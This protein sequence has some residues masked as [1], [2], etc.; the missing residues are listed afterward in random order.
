MR[1]R[2]IGSAVEA[3]V[4]AMIAGSAAFGQL[5]ISPT[6]VELTGY[7]GGLETFVLGLSNSG[8]T[9][10]TCRMEVAAMTVQAGGIPVAV[11]DGPRSCKDWMSVKPERFTLGLGEN[12]RVVCRIRIPRMTSGGYYALLSCH[13]TPETGPGRGELGSG[14][15]ASIRF[16]YRSMAVVMLRVSGREMRAII[17]PGEPRISLAEQDGGY[18]FELPLR[19]R[20]N[21]H[22]RIFG[23]VEIRSEAGQ[24]VERFDLEA[25]RGFVL[26]MQER[27]FTSKGSLNLPD[28]LYLALVALNTEHSRGPMRNSFPFYVQ[29]GRPIASEPTADVRAKLHEESAGFTVFPSQTTVILSGGARRTR[30]IELINFTRQTLPIRAC[31]MEWIRDAQGSD[32]VAEENPA[33]GRS[34][35]ALLSL[36]QQDIELRPLARR[37]LPLM[38]SLPKGATGERYAAVSFDRADIQLDSSPKGRVRRSSLISIEAQGTAEPQAEIAGFSA[39]RKPNGTVDFIAEIK[40]TGNVGFVPEVTFTLLDSN[41]NS[42]GRI[43]SEASPSFVQSGGESLVSAEWSRVLNP[44]QYTVVLT[45]RFDPDRSPIAQRTEFVVPE[46]GETAG[47]ADSD[48]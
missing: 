31:V 23:A 7:P 2:V 35:R 43:E 40:N 1:R 22:D 9:Q 17:E 8:N 36:R 25:G 46:I 26:P 14:V 15:A 13:A 29:G 18:V 6:I 48:E 41:D 3:L 45:L 27:L 24:L 42:A 44:G 12:R 16:S 38:V 33:H 11:E 10:L 5:A 20:G 28:G 32:R 4:L 34:G 30:A 47:A 21:V 37:S 39:N 19:N